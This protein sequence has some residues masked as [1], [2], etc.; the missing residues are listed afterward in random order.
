MINFDIAKL[1]IQHVYVKSVTQA[2]GGAMTVA[3]LDSEWTQRIPIPYAVARRFIKE[4]KVQNYVV[5]V[6][7]AVMYYDNIVVALERHHL[8]NLGVAEEEGLF[9]KKV[10]QSVMERYLEEVKETISEKGWYTDGSYV[11]R[12]QPE[13]ALNRVAL[14]QDG[15]YQ[16]V[17]ADCFKFADFQHRDSVKAASQKQSEKH[18]L[19]YTT[20]CGT[21]VISPPIWANVKSLSKGDVM[22]VEKDGKKEGGDDVSVVLQGDHPYDKI[23]D[24]MLVNINFALSAAKELSQV[25]GY[26]SIE[27]LCLDDLMV[28]MKTV[29]LPNLETH[30]KKTCEIGMSYTHAVAWLMGFV[31]RSETL[32]QLMNVRALL[33]YLSSTGSYQKRKLTV[34]AIFKA[35]RSLKDVPMIDC[36]IFA[37]DEVRDFVAQTA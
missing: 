35:E 7:S 10:W 23:N 26:E 25:F 18:C 21:R 4:H 37:T 11:Y 5:P 13:T 29:N 16:S 33:K 36:S 17:G 14:S 19:M 31:A 32:E 15:K 12:I 1:T 30:V 28:K 20:S 3:E 22:A 24:H 9:G 34:T 27:P 8:G 2:L 6:L